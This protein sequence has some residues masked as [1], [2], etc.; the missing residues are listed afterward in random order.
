MRAKRQCDDFGNYTTTD[1]DVKRQEALST[2]IRGNATGANSMRLRARPGH[3][4]KRAAWV[5]ALHQ[6]LQG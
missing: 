4:R 3:G 2:L 1:H 5:E 6:D